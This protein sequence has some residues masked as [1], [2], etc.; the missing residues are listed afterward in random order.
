MGEPSRFAATSGLQQTAPVA[1]EFN[2]VQEQVR[3]HS[4]CLSLSLSL[5]FWP[6]ALSLLCFILLTL[7]SLSVRLLFPPQLCP[8]PA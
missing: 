8:M 6:G 3:H 5:F 2:V 7:A 4:V 1:K